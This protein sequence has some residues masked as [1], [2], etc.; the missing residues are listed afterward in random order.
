MTKEYALNLNSAKSTQT[1][2]NLK[3]TMAEN[4]EV[5]PENA[6]LIAGG[7]PV[8]LLLA[9]VLAHYGVKSVLLERNKTT[10]K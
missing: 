9:T 1:S 3:F 2:A 10:T 7:G 8:G 5:L 4:I 6:V